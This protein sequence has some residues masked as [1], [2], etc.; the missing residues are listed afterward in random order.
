MLALLVVLTSCRQ[1]MGQIED[2]IQ[3]AW[4]TDAVSP[5][6]VPGDPDSVGRLHN[7]LL[8]S[9]WQ[10]VQRSGDTTAVGKKN[11]IIKY[12]REHMGMDVR[13]SFRKSEAY[14]K[15]NPL[16]YGHALE[17]SHFQERTRDLLRSLFEAIDRTE[18]L[19]LYPVLLEEIRQLEDAA[20]MSSI[21]QA[22]KTAFRQVSSVARYSARFW[23][24]K[25]TNYPLPPQDSGEPLLRYFAHLHAD[26]LGALIGIF[27]GNAAAESADM[28][29]QMVWYIDAFL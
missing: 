1:E 22:E 2:Q 29:S 25:L 5:I 20:V 8:E 4:E 18:D 7:I 21:P 9:V 3:V 17:Q 14:R 15:D 23:K 13:D 11:C 12:F 6:I 19:D 24:D 26:V 16:T 28:S 10:Y 27:S